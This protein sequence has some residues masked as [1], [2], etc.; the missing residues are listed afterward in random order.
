VLA[1]HPQ[2]NVN[3]KD[4]GGETPFLLGCLRGKV[5]VVKILMKDSHVDINMADS[6]GCT[7]L[8][9][10]SY[11]GLVEVIKW[12]IASGREINLDKNGKLYSGGKEYTAI[13]KTS[14]CFRL[15]LHHCS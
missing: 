6:D 14:W 15:C 11:Y 7:P 2:I 12:M 1:A 4:N 10:A 13:G 5:E 3:Q 9:W 8:W